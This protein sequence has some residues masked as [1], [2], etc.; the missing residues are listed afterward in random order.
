MQL[1]FSSPSLLLLLF[2]ELIEIRENE[3]DGKTLKRENNKKVLKEDD[4]I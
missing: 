3:D 1:V 2:L 4:G